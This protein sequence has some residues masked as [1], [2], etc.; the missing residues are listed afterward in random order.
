MRT[1]ARQRHR[2]M[3]NI[4]PMKSFNMRMPPA[5]VC[6]LR[7]IGCENDHNTKLGHV[8]MR[9]ACWKRR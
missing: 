8:H 1:L 2:G 3:T 6:F 7:I 9:K 4:I 5:N